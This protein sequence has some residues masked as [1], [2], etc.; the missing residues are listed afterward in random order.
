M[1]IYWSGRACFRFMMLWS[2][3][4]FLSVSWTYCQIDSTS[5]WI[6]YSETHRYLWGNFKPGFNW[7]ISLT[8]SHLTVINWDIHFN[9]TSE[10]YIFHSNIHFYI[11][12]H[13]TQINI[14]IGFIILL[15]ED[16]TTSALSCDRNWFLKN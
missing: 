12:I 1:L 3:D 13:C 6:E 4:F 2:A 10:T 11:H 8:A 5:D 7:L 14:W 16:H 15:T 9:T